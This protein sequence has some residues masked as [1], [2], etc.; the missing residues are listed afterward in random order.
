MAYREDVVWRADTGA[1][2]PRSP[3]LMPPTLGSVPSVP[4]ATADGIPRL[5]SWLGSLELTNLLL[6]VIL[7]VLI[8][9]RD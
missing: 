3:I 7:V 4:Q 5:V 9:R 2:H 1:Y 6:L 8:L